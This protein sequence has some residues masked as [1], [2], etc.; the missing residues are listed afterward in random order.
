MSA[1]AGI[2]C[3]AGNPGDHGARLA[4]A[5]DGEGTGKAV[6]R[7]GSGGVFVFRQQILTPEDR[8][9]HQPCVGRDSGLVSMFAGRLDNRDELLA[10]LGLVSTAAAPLP[11]GEIV[12]HA[13]ERWGADAPPHLLGDFAWAVW[14]G[15]LARLMLARDHSCLRTLFYCVIPGGIAFATGYRALLALPEVPRTLNEAAVVDIIATSPTADGATIYRD[16]RWVEPACRV[17]ADAGGIR[18]DRFWEPAPKGVLRLSRDEEYVEAAQEIFRKAL[19]CRL[20]RIG[21]PVVALSGGQDSS[22]VAATLARDLAPERIIGLTMRPTADFTSADLGADR[23]ADERDKVEALARRYP[24]IDVEF[25][26]CPPGGSRRTDPAGVFLQGTPVRGPGNLVWFS[27]LLDRARELGASTLLSGDYGNYTFSAEGYSYLSDLRR[28]RRWIAF[29]RELILVR[30]SAA[31]GRWR[32]L[33]RSQAESVAPYLLRLSRRLRGLKE[34]SPGWRRRW[35]LNPHL[36]Q[37]SLRAHIERDCANGIDP[38]G[39]DG[40]HRLVRYVITRSRMQAD[41][42]ALI[43]SLWGIDCR[44]PYADRRVIEFCLSLPMDQFMRD[45]VS[46]HLSRRMFADCLPLEILNEGRRGEQNGDW[47]MR[48]DAE[49]KD[50]A[51]ELDHLESSPLACRLL[52]VPYMQQTLRE[53]PTDRDEALRHGVRY[54]CCLNRAIHVGRF[55]RWHEGGNESGN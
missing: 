37:G 25:L 46:R 52:D 32:G 23:Y 18:S 26:T 49:R 12:R 48:M 11:D 36:Y 1:F 27:P 55:L 21:P 6:I 41:A 20:R 40:Y 30:R 13:Y 51:A 4:Q 17:L 9:E 28:D 8:W 39:P 3:F 44:D 31:P 43:R 42:A 29:L 33:L 5:L 50:L 14:D 38:M 45:G 10:D 35:A 19:T 7:T 2:L 22:A 16:I 53:L 15:R 47:F 24:N 54:G 34:A